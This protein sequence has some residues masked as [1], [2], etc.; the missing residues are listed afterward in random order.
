M[1]GGKLLELI[2]KANSN[3][4]MPLSSLEPRTLLKITTASG[5]VYEMLVI[6]PAKGLIIFCGG[7]NQQLREPTAFWL[8]GATSGGSGCI[9]G[10][11]CIGL[12]IRMTGPAGLV[13]TSPVAKVEPVDDS[14]RVQE[15]EE[16]VEFLTPEQEEELRKG[17]EAKVQ[18]GLA[19][20]PDDYREWAT[21]FVDHFCDVTARTY[22]LSAIQAAVDQGKLPEMKEVLGRLFTEHWAYRHPDARGLLITEADAEAW[23]AVYEE[24]G[25]QNY[26]QS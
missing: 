19:E 4:G 7:S 1:I 13:T 20:V 26:G 24:S 8:Q 6:D 17:M 18:E 25:V 14:Q 11:I 15:L 12:R 2:E 10:C 16:S 22:A 9:M 3:S 5:S 23:D 21:G